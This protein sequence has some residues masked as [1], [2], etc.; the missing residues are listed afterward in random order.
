MAGSWRTVDALV[1]E[2]SE[3][4]MERTEPPSPPA[5]PTQMPISQGGSSAFD[6]QTLVITGDTN[7]EQ[8]GKG[9]ADVGMVD[10]RGSGRTFCKVLH[11]FLAFSKSL[12]TM[13]CVQDA[14]PDPAL[15]TWPLSS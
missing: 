12:W 1:P 9:V 5:P 11:T 14:F 3:G 6:S 2:E 8:R 4:V 10:G 13:S 15:G 7:A